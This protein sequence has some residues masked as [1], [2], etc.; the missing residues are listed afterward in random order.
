MQKMLLRRISKAPK[1]KKSCL[2]EFLE[3]SIWR[4]NGLKPAVIN[5][6]CHPSIVFLVFCGL[7]WAEAARTN[8]LYRTGVEMFVRTKS[9]TTYLIAPTLS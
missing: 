7:A 6:D 2:V 9:L 1:Q 3:G 5:S 4:E 8:D